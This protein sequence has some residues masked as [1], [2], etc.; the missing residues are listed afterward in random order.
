MAP[1]HP[2]FQTSHGTGAAEA[3]VKLAELPD[4]LK[5]GGELRSDGNRFSWPPKSYSVP[6]SQESFFQNLGTTW[7]K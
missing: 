3:C 4:S 2:Y 6:L 1:V 5:T 7:M